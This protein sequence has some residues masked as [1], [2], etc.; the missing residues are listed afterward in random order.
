[1][2]CTFPYGN[3]ILENKIKNS[4]IYNGIKNFSLNVLIFYPENSKIML[5]EIKEIVK[6]VLPSHRV[7]NSVLLRFYFSPQMTYRPLI[8]IPNQNPNG[9]YYSN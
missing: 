5:R 6:E 2:S 9:F 4:T 8:H 3:D 7:E 1:M